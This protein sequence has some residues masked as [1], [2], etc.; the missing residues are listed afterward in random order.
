MAHFLRKE[1]GAVADDKSTSDQGDGGV[2]NDDLED[3]LTQL[4]AVQA[5]GNTNP[6]ACAFDLVFLFT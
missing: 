4:V 5:K 2:A 1:R 6:R 3:D